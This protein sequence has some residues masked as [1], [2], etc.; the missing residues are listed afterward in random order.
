MI[1]K[2]N[3]KKT[4]KTIEKKNKKE[5]ENDDKTENKNF[6]DNKK[7]IIATSEREYKKDGR[8]VAQA[9]SRL[10]RRILLQD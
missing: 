9:R 6:D 7:T 2:I 5:D 10:L 3:E 8:V 1:K 4:K